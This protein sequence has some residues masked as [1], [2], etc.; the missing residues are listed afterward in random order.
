MSETVN[1]I[2]ELE[3]RIQRLERVVQETLTQELEGLSAQDRQLIERLPVKDPAAK[4]RVVQ[5]LKAAGKLTLQNSPTV[6][7]ITR[8]SYRD[9]LE[10]LRDRLNRG[11]Q[12]AKELRPPWYRGRQGEPE[13]Y[14][15]PEWR[16]E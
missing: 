11:R 9:E 7:T 5:A 14:M 12:L 3:A 13:G 2:E 1:H 8:M 16:T 6:G 15:P 4:L 10:W